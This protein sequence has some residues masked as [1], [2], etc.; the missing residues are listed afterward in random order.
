ME[1]GFNLNK[2]DIHTEDQFRDMLKI[3]GKVV[4]CS[5]FI[6][7]I[8]HKTD[9]RWVPIIMFGDDDNKA[10]AHAFEVRGGGAEIAAFVS[11]LQ[12]VQR[13]CDRGNF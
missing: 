11:R 13:N 2:L 10:F 4:Q 5:W 6:G 7:A 9:Q 12:A 1:N 8:R 3:A